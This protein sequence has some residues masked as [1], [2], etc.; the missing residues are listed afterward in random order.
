MQSTIL[1]ESES[2]NLFNKIDLDY[3]FELKK[4]YENT[5]FKNRSFYKKHE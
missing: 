4:E 3:S 2:I 1:S 5:F